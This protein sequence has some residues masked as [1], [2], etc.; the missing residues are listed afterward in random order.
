LIRVALV[1]P[2]LAVR[3]GLRSLLSGSDEL[4]VIAEAADLNELESLS[5]EADVVII[6]S[7]SASRSDL[8]ELL[9]RSDPRPAV[10]LISEVPEDAQ[11]LAGLPVRAW[12]ILPLDTSSEELTAAVRALG[13]G[14]LVGAPL[15]MEHLLARR[16]ADEGGDADSPVEAL[17]ARETEVLQLLAQGLANKQIAT[18]LRISEHTVKFHV[19]SIYTK[20]GVMNRTE[21]ARVGVRRGLITL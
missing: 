6:T 5:P 17:T 16:L 7:A 4:T 19:S 14:L 2:A 1:V 11:A 18:K 13:E 15:L 8:A 10:L 3:V 21:A 20:L 9:S 12:G